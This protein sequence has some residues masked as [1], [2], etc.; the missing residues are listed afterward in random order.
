MKVTLGTQD[1]EAALKQEV[2]VLLVAKDKPALKH[3]LHRI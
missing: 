1:V 3:S 2:H